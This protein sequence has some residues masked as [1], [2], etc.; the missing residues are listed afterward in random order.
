MILPVDD[1]LGVTGVTGAPVASTSVGLGVTPSFGL[2][3]DAGADS[4]VGS[5]VIFIIVGIGVGRTCATGL[6]VWSTGAGVSN[7][8]KEKK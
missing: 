2:G 1:G 3:V 4:S 6:D 7:F 8:N 5:G